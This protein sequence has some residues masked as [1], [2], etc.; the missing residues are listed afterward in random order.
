MFQDAPPPLLVQV[1]IHSFSQQIF[2]EHLLCARLCL[3]AGNTGAMN[4]IAMALSVSEHTTFQATFYHSP[5]IYIT[6]KHTNKSKFCRIS[7]DPP[8]NTNQLIS[9]REREREKERERKR[10]RRREAV[11]REETPSFVVVSQN[12][13]PIFVIPCSKLP[14]PPLN[15]RTHVHMFPAQFTFITCTAGEQ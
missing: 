5:P 4:K 3:G 9:E 8:K 1:G 2:P 15:A 10:G 6:E 14:C 11:A 13:G 7:L 12:K